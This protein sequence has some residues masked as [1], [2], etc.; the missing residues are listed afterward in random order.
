MKIE[1]VLQVVDPSGLTFFLG[2]IRPAQI[3]ELTFVPSVV[4]VNEDVLNVRTQDG[5][6]R[7]GAKKRMKEI[8]KF[9][10]ENLTSLVPPVLLSTRSKWIFKPQTKGSAFGSLETEDCAA[11]IDGQHRLG[12]MSIIAQTDGNPE[13][14]NRSIPFLAVQYDSVERES[15]EF[16]VING[17]QK[18]I[19]ASHLKYIKRSKNFSG[20]AAT[21]LAED[22]DSVFCGRI[23]ISER[24][25]WDLLTFGAATEI[26]DLCFSSSFTNPANLKLKD[27]EEDQTKALSF[28]N[29][30]WKAVAQKFDGMWQE[31][32]KLPPPNVPKSKQHPGRNK[33]DFRLLEETGLRAF[34]MLAPRIFSRSWIQQERDIAV[35][36]VEFFL[37]KIASDDQVNLVLQKLSAEN[38]EQLIAIDPRLQYSGKSGAG[39]IFEILQAALDKV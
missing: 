24:K 39:P 4:K 22:E 9:Y 27:S 7:E 30:Y 15:E 36:K 5:Y 6:Q 32:H 38:K 34:A 28:L 2:T 14:Q 17:R 26:V 19:K 16:E 11:V 10:S 18:G 8:A 12:G 1:N 33:F 31:I 3:M 35:E 21:M 37:E 29:A 25:D 23:A 20:N 13:A